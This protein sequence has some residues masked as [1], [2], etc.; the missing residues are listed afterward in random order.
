MV[1]N[2]T[3]GEAMPI[4]AV[5]TFFPLKESWLLRTE[6]RKLLFFPK[7]FL[8]YFFILFSNHAKALF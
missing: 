6:L 1:L 4:R 3:H 2:T 8:S 7:C 5:Y